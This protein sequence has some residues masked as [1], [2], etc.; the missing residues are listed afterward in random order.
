MKSDPEIN[1][2]KHR[3]RELEDTVA[4][5]KTREYQLTNMLQRINE[6]TESEPTD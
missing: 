3:I 4:H 2:L 1:A 5:Y 6:I